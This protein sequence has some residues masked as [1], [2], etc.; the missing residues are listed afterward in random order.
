[1]TPD[2]IPQLAWWLLVVGGLAYGLRRPI[3][4]RPKPS[5]NVR[6][7][8]RPSLKRLVDLDH[9]LPTDLLVKDPPEKP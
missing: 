9:V 1:M 3:R 5:G 2:L 4:T 7:R 8:P 6:K